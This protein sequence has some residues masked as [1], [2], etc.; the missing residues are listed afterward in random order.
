MATFNESNYSCTTNITKQC[1]TGTTSPAL[2]VPNIYNK[3]SV[4]LS[5]ITTLIIV[6]N[7]YTITL[8]SR[9]RKLRNTSNIIL[10][11]MTVGE[12]VLGAIG[13][14]VSAILLAL[15]GNHS[16]LNILTDVRISFVLQLF[17]ILTGKFS[18]S[19]LTAIIGERCFALYFP[20]RN[21]LHKRKA[22]VTTVVSFLWILA[23]GFTFIPF[24]WLYLIFFTDL[25]KIKFSVE[26]RNNVNQ[27][28]ERYNIGFASVS[29]V[30]GSL[31]L[32][33]LISIFIKIRRRHTDKHKAGVSFD[34]KQQKQE[35][36]AAIVLSIMAGTV[37]AWLIPTIIILVKLS[38]RKLNKSDAVERYMICQLARFSIS[39]FNPILYTLYKSDFMKAVQEDKS[40]LS[41][42]VDSLLCYQKVDEVTK[43]MSSPIGSKR[44][45]GN[46]HHS[47]ER[48]NDDTRM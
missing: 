43:H 4:S 14:V 1:Q 27:N 37:L 24:F 8:Y 9:H 35:I 3:F 32:L 48:L 18:I 10:F 22:K 36:R 28:Q 6:L 33:G 44:G 40:R 42:K 19:H 11:S 5:V 25:S 13:L 26:L 45:E 20:L 15:Y 39:I 12:L 29:S 23:L 34:Q 41:V 17:L 30:F 46:Q 31:I 2:M 21:R 38:K 16:S 47:D 7:F